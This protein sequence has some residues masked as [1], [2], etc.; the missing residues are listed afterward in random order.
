VGPVPHHRCYAKQEN[1][2]CSEVRVAIRVGQHG[3]KLDGIQGASGND[4]RTV[5]GMLKFGKQV[6]KGRKVL[7][8]L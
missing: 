7:S 8:G 4:G 5:L 6:K 1:I 3:D 2:S